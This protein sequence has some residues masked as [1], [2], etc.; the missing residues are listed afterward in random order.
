MHINVRLPLQAFERTAI[1]EALSISVIS[2]SSTVI[3]YINN[4]GGIKSKK[5]NEIAM[6]IWLWCF[7]NDYFSYSAHI[8]EKH[9]I[10]ADEFSR[11]FSNNTE[12][13]IT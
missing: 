12:R 4:K 10:E 7:K 2:G 9:N 6:E 13:P 5:C 8:P 3:V 1:I 11:K